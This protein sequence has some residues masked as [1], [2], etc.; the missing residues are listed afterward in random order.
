MI[1]I[2]IFLFIYFFFLSFQGEKSLYNEEGQFEC[3]PC[4]EGCESCIDKRPC[5]VSLNWVMRTIILVLS[6]VIILFL[7]VIV[8]FTWKY[9]NVKVS[10]MKIFFVYRPITADTVLPC[11]AFDLKSFSSH[12]RTQPS[13]LYSKIRIFSLFGQ[14]WPSAYFREKTPVMVKYSLR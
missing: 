9:G 14:K 4:A 13:F 8:F 11:Q 10:V 6:C 3:L 7:P 5:V 2:L 12:I 1:I